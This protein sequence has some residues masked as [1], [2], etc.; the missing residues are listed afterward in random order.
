M[1]EN[2]INI[3]ARERLHIFYK[4]YHIP[5]QLDLHVEE[6]DYIIEMCVSSCIL[7]LDLN[8]MSR[9]QF[10]KESENI[11]Q[12]YPSWHQVQGFVH[13]VRVEVAPNRTTLTF[14]EVLRVIQEILR[15]LG[16]LHS[17]HCQAM[18]S[19]LI[20]L[21]EDTVGCVHLSNF[22]RRG[23]TSV[24]QWL[25][26]ERDSYLRE[27]G[28]L[29]ET[30]RQYVIVP[31]YMGAPSNCISPS[32]YYSVCCRDECM[33]IM[34]SLERELRMPTAAPRTLAKLVTALP[35]SSKATNRTLP[36]VLLHRLDL[37]GQHY[38]GLV[39]LSSP[40]FAQWLHQAYPRKCPDVTDLLP[41]AL[42]PSTSPRSAVVQGKIASRSSA[43]L[44]A[45][46]LPPRG[47]DVIMTPREK[48]VGHSESGR[49]K[50]AICSFIAFFAACA[51][52]A[53]ILRQQSRH[54]TSVMLV[55]LQ[56]WTLQKSG[57][58]KCDV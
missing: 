23:T 44:G 13:D 28:A 55:V 15:S 27:Q 40:L 12:I 16:R 18:K 54:I 21:E 38:E 4:M 24:G 6:V 42:P 56:S 50:W 33:E 46:C 36:P 25:F 53:L 34:S 32:S 47:D 20:G 45:R 31:N 39:P 58:A 17:R 49:V 26:N 51:S 19:K 14:T 30:K 8:Q 37:L 1:L 52:F 5:L 11:A 35:S 43:L 22:Q 7:G 57:N 3:E 9:Q 10:L 2:L 29:D 48:S 41:K